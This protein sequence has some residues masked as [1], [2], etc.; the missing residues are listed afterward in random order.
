MKQNLLLLSMLPFAL[1]AQEGAVR[2]F[3]VPLPTANAFYDFSGVG[4]KGF[5]SCFGEGNNASTSTLYIHQIL[6][7]ERPQSTLQPKLRRMDHNTPTLPASM[8]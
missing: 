3:A 6:H 7:R 5:I 8:T 2:Q 4:E 1:M